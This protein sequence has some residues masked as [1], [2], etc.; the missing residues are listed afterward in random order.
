MRVIETIAGVREAVRQARGVGQ[1]VGLVPTMG[2]L[3]AG[4]ETLIGRS[5][6]ECD[7]T[8]VSIFV[9]PIQFNQREDFEKYPRTWERDLEACESAGVGIVFAPSN[10][11]MYPRPLLTMVEPG[12]VAEHLCGRFRQGHFRG[13]ATVVAKLFHAV[14]ADRAYFGEK[15]AQQLAVIQSMVSDLNMAVEI[16]PVATVR[17]DDGLAMSSRNERLST[18]ERRVA[19]VLYAG[20]RAALARL[21]EGEREVRWVR[22]AALEVIEREQL[23]RLEYLEVVDAV[24]MQPVRMVEGPVRV[25]VAAWLGRVRLIDNVGFVPH[26]G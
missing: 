8:V 22:E 26:G 23:V 11:E 18:S 9:N 20:L 3:H 13:V 10:E 15:D 17:E 14:E 21:E 1:R 5:V 19:P 2:A 16:V 25:A 7:A 6:A 4:H 24:A 12:A